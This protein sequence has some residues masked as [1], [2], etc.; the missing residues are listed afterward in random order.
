MALSLALGTHAAHRF[1]GGM[2]AN[3]AAV[4]HLDAGDVEGVRRAGPDDLHKAGNAD[5]HQL[6]LLALLFLLFAKLLVAD[7]FQRQV[8]RALVV[9]AVVAPAQS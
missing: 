5:A 4:E 9:A 8:H 3:L 6:A 2:N 1:A 7:L